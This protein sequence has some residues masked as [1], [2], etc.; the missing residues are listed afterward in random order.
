MKKHN[1]KK[2]NSKKKSIWDFFVFDLDDSRE[3]QWSFSNSFFFDDDFNKI[4]N[5][6]EFFFSKNRKIRLK[7][8]F[9][10]FW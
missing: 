2:K 10:F 7:C 4:K 1:E 8:F 6:F 5:I 9:E 3:W